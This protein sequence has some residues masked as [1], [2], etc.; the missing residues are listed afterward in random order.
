[1][2]YTGYAITNE[3]TLDP[4]QRAALGRLFAQVAAHGHGFWEANQVWGGPSEK[5][6]WLTGADG[7]PIAHL[8]Y[9]LRTI[10]VGGQ[11]VRLAGI[12]AVCVSP[13]HRGLG[14]SR[15]LFALL[16]ATVEADFGLLTCADVAAALG[17]LRVQQPV[18]CLE[19]DTGQWADCLGPFFVVALR[20]PLSAWPSLG[21]IEL[22]AS[23]W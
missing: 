11:P 22:R 3:R 9:G 14:L 18:R 10:A 17:A 2:M 8:A 19:P 20:Q 4:G 5:R 7:E 12:G 1:M 6:I 23:Q 15:H 16:E 13:E 21:P